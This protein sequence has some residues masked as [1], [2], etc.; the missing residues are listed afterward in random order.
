[1]RTGMKATINE[2]R[3]ATI[4]HLSRGSPH[5][6]A[7]LEGE[8]VLELLNAFEADPAQVEIVREE[9]GRVVTLRL[10]DPVADD[11]AAR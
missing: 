4:E 3:S 11:Y 9:R 7:A 10:V 2:D 8:I 6:A 5:L 1:M